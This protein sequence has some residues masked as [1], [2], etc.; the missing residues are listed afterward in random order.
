MPGIDELLGA[1]GVV[2][3]LLLWQVVGQVVTAM[4]SPA[5]NALQ[6]DTMKAHPNMVLTPDILARAVTDTFITKGAAV[7]EAERSGIDATRFDTL[8]ELATVRITPADLA[9]A[10]LRSYLDHS[11]AAHEAQLQGVDAERFNTMTLLA[12]DGIGPEQAA[13]ALRRGF[14]AKSGMGPDSTSYE[15]AI[16][17]SRLHNKWGP[18]LFELTKALLSPPDLAQAVVRGFMAQGHAES[19]AAIAGVDATDFAVMVELAADAPSPTEL[20]EALRRGLI[21]FDAGSANGVGFVQGIREGRLADKWIAMIQ[22]LAK[23]WPTPTDALE[24]RLVGQVTDEES[25]ELYARFGG[26][27]EWWSL[28]FH[29]RG[30]SPTPLELISMANRGFIPWDGLGQNVTSYAQGFHEGRWRDKW[31]D[32]YKRFAEYQPSEGTITTLLAHGVITN[33][34][35][36][37]YYTKLGM[38]DALIGQMVDEAHTEALSDY[39]GATVSMVLQAYYQQLITADQARPILY[40]LHVTPIAADFMLLYEDM[41]RAFTAL[42]NA[43]T[44]IRT[45]FAN[46]KITLQTATDSLTQL[47]I[48]PVT[49]EGILRS[50]EVENSITV[51][52]L[53]EAQIADAF[54]LGIFSQDQA[55][56]ELVNIGYTPFDA[57]ALLSIKMKTALPNPPPGG[58]APPQAAVIPGTT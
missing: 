52:V 21:P 28:L 12:G 15:Q 55:I 35:A 19:L 10:V 45:L 2:E 32:V 54:E 7:A 20:A 39:R 38:S 41:Q 50:W 1:S 43:L 3:Q 27:P 42:N 24:A 17:E 25:Q 37:D 47:G 44:R 18:T 8:L 34:Q 48:A 49:I 6:Q 14:I 33:E 29:T 23:L 58:P 36:T 16:A 4:M 5:F 56:T 11:A 31:Q 26:D 51:K 13:E 40:A 30:E 9:E 53:T 46:R 57:W 22:G